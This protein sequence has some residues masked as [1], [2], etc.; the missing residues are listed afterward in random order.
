MLLT[1]RQCLASLALVI[2]ALAACGAPSAGSIPAPTTAAPAAQPTLAAPPAAAATQAPAAGATAAPKAVVTT[3]AT[4]IQGGLANTVIYGTFADAK[5]LNP[6]LLSDTASSTITGLIFEGLVTADPKTGQPSPSLAQKWEQSDDGLTY[7]FHLQPNVTWSDGQPFTAEDAK[8]TFDT[9]LDPKV[10][11]PRKSN[12]E[13]VKS[14][15][16][17]DPLTLKATLKQPFCPF[18]ISSMGIGIVPKHILSKSANINTDDFNTKTPVG[19]GPYTLKEWLKDDHITLVANPTYWKGKPKIDQWVQKVVKDVTVVAAQLKTSEVD[20]ASIEAKDLEDMQKQQNVT[21]LTYYRL[22]YDYIGYNLAN[23]LLADKKLRQALTHA[24]DRNVFVQKIL[25]GQGQV[26]DGPTPPNAWAFNPDIPSFKFDVDASKQLL[27]DAGWVAG[28]DGILQKDGKPLKFTIVT[29]AGNKT[30]ESIATIAQDQWKKIGVQVDTS[31]IEF[32]ALLDK[33]NKTHDFDAFVLGWALS[34]DPDT[35]S[36]WESTSYPDSLN[37]IKYSNTEVDKLSEQARSLPGCSQDGRKALYGKIQ[38][39]I[40]DDQ[41]YTFLYQ[42]K[43]IVTINKRVKG[44]D[45]SATAG[46]FWN[47]QDWTLAK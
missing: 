10:Q 38:Q 28:A 9:I 34:L 5:I 42:A 13:I 16:V 12:Y 23:P 15:D 26:V 1:R 41:P 33:L 20:I 22:G 30:R 4:A 24:L 43:S 37:S 36:I 27:K 11:S 25:Y 29:N 7:T 8:F 46:L 6:F 32:G 31:F 35:K 44:V 3:P 21:T 17:V 45:P 39:L 14:F 47:I 18:L 19:T 2:P 40:A